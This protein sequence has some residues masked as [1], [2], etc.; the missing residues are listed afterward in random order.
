MSEWISQEQAAVCLGV[1]PAFVRQMIAKGRLRLHGD[2]QL[3]PEQVAELATLM[4]RLRG[5]GFATLVAAADG[6]DPE[7]P[8]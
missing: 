1:S 5:E 2:E 3:D 7:P 8:D 4:A 6:Q